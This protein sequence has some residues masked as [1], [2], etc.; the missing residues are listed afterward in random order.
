LENC[1]VDGGKL[2]KDVDWIY[3]PPDILLNI[4]MKAEFCKIKGISSTG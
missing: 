4:I 2:S 3:M 1:C